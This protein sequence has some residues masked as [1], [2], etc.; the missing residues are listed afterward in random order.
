MSN[1]TWSDLLICYDQ[2]KFQPDSEGVLTIK[3]E[4]ILKTITQLENDNSDAKSCN[5]YAKD[6]LTNAKVGD[7]ISVHVGPPV[8]SLGRLA[9]T[10]DILLTSPRA[11]IEFP[12]HFYV[13]ENKLSDRDLTKRSLL[14]YR[15]VISLVSLLAETATYLDQ[16]EQKL[17]YFKDGKVE[18]PVRY[19]AASLDSISLIDIQSLLSK[20]EGDA[21]HRAQK[22]T[23]LAEAVA[24]IVRSQSEGA[25]F[26]TIL[27]NLDY[28]AVSVED[29]YRLFVS[30]F[31]YEKIK[32][33]VE[34]ANLDFIS[35]IHRTFV[36]VQGQLLGVPIAAVVVAS[37]MKVAEKCGLEVWTNVAVLAGAWVFVLFLAASIANQFLTLGAISTEVK[38]QKNSLESDFAAVS[39]KFIGYFTSLETRIC[40][41]RAIFVIV[42]LVG[43]AGAAFAT[44]AYRALTVPSASLCFA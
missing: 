34:A 35:K 25:R 32:S 15:A 41:Y 21:L 28:L 23:I 26:E 18:V 14:A 12:T 40:W 39:S 9:R 22:L 13:V 1:V 11:Y 2:T 6:D 29:G 30:S 43:L 42:G 20:F 38:R 31:S 3:S 19:N 33:D 5:L 7:E 4:L 44:Y 37:Q 36:D 8:L 27:R 16:M 24:S 10:L 17:F